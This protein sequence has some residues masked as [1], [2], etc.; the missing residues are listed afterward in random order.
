MR[1]IQVRRKPRRRV[2]EHADVPLELIVSQEKAA[3]TRKHL[4]EELAAVL[5]R[6][7]RT[8]HEAA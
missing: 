8:L 7:D 1:R 3:R 6:I 5:E 4:C 2:E